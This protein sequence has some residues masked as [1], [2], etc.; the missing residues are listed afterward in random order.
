M[1][2]FIQITT[3]TWHQAPSTPAPLSTPHP[4][5]RPVTRLHHR[6]HRTGT[7]G[8]APAP[9]RTA[10]VRP[11]PQRPARHRHAAVAQPGPSGHRPHRP[12]PAASALRIWP[13][14]RRP[15][16]A[17][18]RRPGP[19][20]WLAPSSLCLWIDTHHRRA[21][22][23]SRG[24]DRHRP[25]WPHRHRTP[26]PAFAFN[27]RARPA[28]THR[29]AAVTRTV[30]VT[31]H[32]PAAP[33]PPPPQ[34][35]AGVLPARRRRRPVPSLR[36]SP[37]VR[38]RGPPRQQPVAPAGPQHSVIAVTVTVAPAAARRRHPA[39]TPGGG[40]S[41]AVRW[42][43][44]VRPHSRRRLPGRQASVCRFAARPLSPLARAA[45]TTPQQRSRRARPPSHARRTPSRPLFVARSARRSRRSHSISPPCAIASLAATT[46][47]LR[48]G[49][50]GIGWQRQR[51][52]HPGRAPAGLGRR[53]ALGN[54]T[55]PGRSARAGGLAGAAGQRRQRQLAVQHRTS[56]SR[57]R[58][59]PASRPD[60]ASSNAR[61]PSAPD[62]PAVSSPLQPLTQRTG[63]PQVTLQLS[64]ARRRRHRD[65]PLRRRHRSIT[66]T[67]SRISHPVAH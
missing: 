57:H 17:L 65:A 29:L 43:A 22:G 33:Q 30:T 62:A 32:R 50:P 4:G 14:S 42:P 3:S 41:G 26:G 36:P 21:T 61:P 58:P 53:P 6:R 52:S 11:P 63:L 39:R 16:A 45:A 54:A 67:A 55:R 24:I 5:L 2:Q 60:T 1:F 59:P 15:A 37:P 20:L 49:G 23:A 28:R 7:A 9:A 13:S 34:P 19:S 35:G 66:A 31:G 27:V 48:P 47:Q 40:P 64:V 51:P 18:H 56:G 25:A 8:P 38:Q 44:F 46:N 10:A 12:A